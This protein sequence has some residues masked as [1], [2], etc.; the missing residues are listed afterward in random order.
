M[1]KFVS[2][3][4][5]LALYT[6]W[7][8]LDR[9]ISYAELGRCFNVPRYTARYHCLKYEFDLHMGARGG[10]REG[11]FSYTPET[12]LLIRLN[13]L[14]IVNFDPV[15]TVGEIRLRVINNLGIQ[16]STSYIQRIFQGW[17]WSWKR[18]VYVNL[19]KFRPDNLEV[20]AAHLVH[21]KEI[22]WRHLKYVDESHFISKSCLRSQAIGPVGVPYITVNREKIDFR[23]TLTAMTTFTDTIPVITKL[24]S[25]S[26][27][28]H[29]FLVFIAE[30]IQSGYLN[31]GDYLIMDNA[32]VHGGGDTFELLLDLLEE[33]GAEL[34]FLPKYSPELNP[35]EYIF[36]HIKNYL[37]YNRDPDLPFTLSILE[38][39]ALLDHQ[40]LYKYYK[41]CINNPKPEV[42]DVLNRFW[43]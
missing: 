39:I 32:S 2:T 28:Q 14:R 42:S 4:M 36:G 3:D 23:F 31:D 16:I 34:I 19:R 12:D 5:S 24:N 9:N 21:I 7:I 29:D 18:P 17:N 6:T 8:L 10:A 40:L 13:V 25:G 35:V 38:A 33:A 26:N 30:C 41:Q 15:T 1:G 22:D 37:K 43:N 27:T 11:R 20:Y